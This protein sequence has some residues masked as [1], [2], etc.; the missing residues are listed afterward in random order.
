MGYANPSR[1]VALKRAVHGIIELIS[2]LFR[3]LIKIA[4]VLLFLAVFVAVVILDNA[5]VRR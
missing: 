1:P 5:A 2:V 4:L 3:G